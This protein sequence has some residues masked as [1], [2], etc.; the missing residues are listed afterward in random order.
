MVQNPKA[1]FLLL[2]QG[3]EAVPIVLVKNPMLIKKVTLL[4]DA[5]F[6]WMN[7]LYI[8]IPWPAPTW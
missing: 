2:L 3:H 5:S 6:H 4:G 1:N 7:D 8:Y